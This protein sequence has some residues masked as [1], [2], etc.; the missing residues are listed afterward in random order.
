MT[1]T[2][3][4]TSLL[5]QQDWTKIYQTFTNA[6]FTSYDFETLRNSMIGYLKTYYPERRILGVI[7]PTIET[8]IERDFKNILLIGTKRTVE[9]K[10]YERELEKSGYKVT[11][12]I[13]DQ[14]IEHYGY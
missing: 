7:I 4:Q 5:V 13:I 1:Q 14:E 6:D 9:S 12:D 3:R 10:K 8:I 2:T 11:E